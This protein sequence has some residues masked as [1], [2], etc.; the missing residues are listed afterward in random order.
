MTTGRRRCSPWW[1]VSSGTHRGRWNHL[2]H[3]SCNRC[4]LLRVARA[5]RC[6]RSR[7]ASTSLLDRRRILD[8]P[9]IRIIALHSDHVIIQGLSVSAV[10]SWDTPKFVAPNRTHLSHSGQV[11]GWTGQMD[12]SEIVED[13]HRETKYR[14]GPNPTL[15]CM[16]LIRT[17]LHHFLSSHLFIRTIQLSPHPVG[18]HPLI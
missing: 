15:A 12:P 11:D 18:F 7:D 8:R 16:S 14:P 5:T 2:C 10:V 13:P 4:S 17:A 1:T 3:R 6:D 9:R